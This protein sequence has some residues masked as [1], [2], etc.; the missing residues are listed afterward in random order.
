MVANQGSTAN[1]NFPDVAMVADGI[2]VF[3]NGIGQTIGGTS[4]AAPL[5]AGFTALVNEQAA[6]MG[7]A[8]AGFLN[9]ALYTIGEGASYT[10]SFHDITSGDNTSPDLRN[11]NGSTSQFHAAPG[12]DL[13]TG[14]GTPNGIN[15]INLLAVDPD[16]G[17]PRG[18]LLSLKVKRLMLVRAPPSA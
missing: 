9:P 15:L 5:W 4:V 3:A 12:Y 17:S 1:R 7:Q 14:W 13:C 10:T 2:Y 6:V 16:R 8:P 11:P 18:L